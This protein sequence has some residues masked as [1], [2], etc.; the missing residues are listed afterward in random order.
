MTLM[1]S[2]EQT[3]SSTGPTITPLSSYPAM[4]R[5][6]ED[7]ENASYG[8]SSEKGPSGS[9]VAAYPES[10]D[11]LA[12]GK[13]NQE[14]L[15]HVGARFMSTTGTGRD[16]AASRTELD[17]ETKKIKD[18]CLVSVRDELGRSLTCRHSDST[19]WCERCAIKVNSNP[20]SSTPRAI[21]ET[22]V[23]EIHLRKNRQ[24]ERVV[25]KK[26]RTVVNL[27]ESVEGAPSSTQK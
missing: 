17:K 18:T 22:K 21:P 8:L 24:S 23:L 15:S 6:D 9:Y 26:P 20:G 19:F 14:N 1:K 27:P 13:T 11:R 2:E 12:T 10:D 16:D 5:L 3:T 25:L 4:L 7:E